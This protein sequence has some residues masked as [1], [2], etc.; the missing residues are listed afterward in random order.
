MKTPE[1]F[2]I[3][4]DHAIFRPL[5]VASLNEAVQM[6]ASAIFFARDHGIQNLLADLTG[7]TGFPSPNVT[8]RYQ[9]IK[10]GAEASGGIVRVAMV[11]RPEIMDPEKVGVVMGK[12]LGL[13]C[14]VF[15]TVPEALAW[16]RGLG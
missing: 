10:L 8:A 6:V 5:C 13:V 14:D 2:E 16:L 3:A 12:H 11:L 7:L 9:L 4:E 15:L 1:Y